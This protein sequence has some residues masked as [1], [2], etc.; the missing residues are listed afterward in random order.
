MARPK[1]SPKLG[2]RTKGTPNKTTVTV[3][4]VFEETFEKMGGVDRL[5]IWAQG[6]PGEFYKLYSKLLPLEVK[7]DVN[8]KGLDA[9][10]E[11]LARASERE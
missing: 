7:A 9:L 3:K 8:H 4:R 1:G 2:G 5:V 10:A 6:D 11:R